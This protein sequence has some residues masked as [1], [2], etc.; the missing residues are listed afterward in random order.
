[1]EVKVVSRSGKDLGTFQVPQEILVK[2][3]KKKFTEKCDV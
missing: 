3:F 2:D 1:M